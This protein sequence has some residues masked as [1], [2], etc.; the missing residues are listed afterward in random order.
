MNRA[1]SRSRFRNPLLFSPVNLFS[2]GAQGAW[3]EASDLSSLYQQAT[4]I[5]PVTAATQP[6]GLRLDKRFGLDRSPQLYSG[7]NIQA[8]DIGGP[9]FT[10]YQILPS[11]IIGATYAITLRV[12]AY[13]GTGN[14]SIAGTGGVEWLVGPM[15]L[16]I[17]GSLQTV[18]LTALSTT[19]LSVFSRSTNTCIFA[20]ISVMTMAG[21]NSFQATAASRPVLADT[22]K[23]IDFD[24]VDDSHTTVFQTALGVNCTVARSIPGSGAQIL[25][26][27]NI[28]TTFVD[29]TDSCAMILI[30]RPLSASETANV[31]AYLNAAAGL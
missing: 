11:R 4:G 29:S 31:T 2:V 1:G 6:V 26:G 5:T 16:T 27:Q 18:F 8:V 15:A 14:V 28:G 20:D 24:G 3:Y 13:S 21:N 25:T 9:A 23:R 7:G 30:D 10:N 12:N 19:P 17:D 22:P